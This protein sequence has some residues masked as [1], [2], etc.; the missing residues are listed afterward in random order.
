[1]IATMMTGKHDDYL[2]HCYDIARHHHER[3]DG[4][5]YPDKLSGED[6]P[7]CARIVA[8]V[9]VYDALVSERCYKKGMTHEEALEIIKKESGTHFDA[10]IVKAMLEVEEQV[11]EIYQKM[12]K[13]E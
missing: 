2:Q 7:L 12:T 8:L 11:R 13:T 3:W 1:M 6:I 4:R 9:D 5:G 10:E